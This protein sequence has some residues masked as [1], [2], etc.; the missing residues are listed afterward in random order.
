M[1]CLSNKAGLGSTQ[2]SSTAMYRQA[3]AQ[4]FF[5]FVSRPCERTA[6]SWL[7]QASGYK[8]EKAVVTGR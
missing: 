7:H 5:Y 2:S 8:D 6:I 1:A 4:L 3:G